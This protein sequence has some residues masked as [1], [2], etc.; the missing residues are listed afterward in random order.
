[1]DREQKKRTNQTIS[2]FI[3][4]LKKKPSEDEVP[5]HDSICRR[6][7]I[8]PSSVASFSTI[9]LALTT[10]HPFF[11]SAHF[12]CP[13]LSLSFFPAECRLLPP[14][15]YPS[16]LCFLIALFRNLIYVILIYYQCLIS[17]DHQCYTINANCIVAVHVYNWSL[18]FSSLFS[19]YK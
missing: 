9:S 4:A 2:T 1:M 17:S 19:I 15:V 13:S 6:Y 18:Y 5:S 11:R 10:Q 7:S 14:S 16:Q 12:T 3:Y 8:K